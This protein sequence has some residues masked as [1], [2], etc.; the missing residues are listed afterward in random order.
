MIMAD[1]AVFDDIWF[2]LLP[3]DDADDV[4]DVEQALI[5]V[6]ASWNR[7]HGHSELLNVEHL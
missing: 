5:P 2:A 1:M 7:D 6:A 3:A 4:K